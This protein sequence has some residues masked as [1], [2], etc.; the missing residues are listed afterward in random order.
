MAQLV[1]HNGNPINTGQLK[2]R[3]AVAQPWGVRK[4]HSQYNL[5]GL[6]PARLARILRQAE[7]GDASAY[8]ELAED[9]EEKYLHY[10]AQIATRK[11]AIKGLEWDN[12]PASEKLQARKIAEFVGHLIPVIKRATFD[13]ADSIGKGYAVAEIM[14][15]TSGTQWKIKALE[16]RDPRWFQFDKIDGRTL[17]MRSDTNPDGEPLTPGKYFVVQIA[18]KSGLP[19]RG[20]LARA[21]CWGWMGV[22]FSTRDWLTFSEEFGKPL[23]LGRYEGGVATPAD[24]E[25]LYEA[26]S[27]LGTDAAA[28]LPKSMEIEFPEVK[29]ARSESGLWSNL[30]DHFDRKISMLVLGQTLTADTGKGGGGSYALGA[31]HNDV[32]RDILVADAEAIADAVNEQL[33]PLIVNLNYAGVSEYPTLSLPV[34]APEDLVAF[35]GIVETAVG[36]GQPVGQKWF[37]E[38]FSIPLPDAGEAVLGKAAALPAEPGQSAAQRAAHAR[39]ASTQDTADKMTPALAAANQAVI[40]RW[41]E[42]IDEMLAQAN[43][44]EQFREDLLTRY[45]ELQADDMVTVMSIALQAINLRGQAEVRGGQ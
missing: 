16:W 21:A 7:E 33:V 32:R 37:S 5:T 18:A 40:D 38:K 30:I 10:A 45:A 28:M 31:V 22:N 23:R 41:V 3:E 19:I 36:I 4:A 17:R 12:D 1:D 11:R 35:A 25:V 44:L 39:A 13:L 42:Q 14:Y 15:D 20:G 43:S 34:P 26:V 24:L 9:M 6:D 29:G 27:S 8:L 2:R